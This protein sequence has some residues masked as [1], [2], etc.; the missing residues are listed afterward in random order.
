MVHSYNILKKRSYYLLNSI[1]KMYFVIYLSHIAGIFNFIGSA[2]LDFENNLNGSHK[3]IDDDKIKLI[4][5]TCNDEECVVQLIDFVLSYHIPKYYFKDTKIC[6]S[7]I[8]TY[9]RISL[10]L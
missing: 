1:T 4:R 6:Y 7:L 2:A 9:C 10:P 5:D 3:N 8:E